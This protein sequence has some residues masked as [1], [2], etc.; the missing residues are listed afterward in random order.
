MRDTYSGFGACQGSECGEGYPTNLGRE[1]TRRRCIIRPSETSSLSGLKPGRPTRR[2]ISISPLGPDRIFRNFLRNRPQ[3]SG[4]RRELLCSPWEQDQH[5]GKLESA[6]ATAACGVRRLWGGLIAFE[7]W[8]ALSRPSHL[9][10]HFSSPPC[11]CNW[12]PQAAGSSGNEEP[13]ADRS[14]SVIYSSGT[15]SSKDTTRRT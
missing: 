14:W 9:P 11:R 10:G 5:M 12:C 1:P 15:E 13:V 8:I 3:E 2:I 6:S 4:Q 7:L